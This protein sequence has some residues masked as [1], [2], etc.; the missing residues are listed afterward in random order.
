[1][2]GRH[3]SVSQKRLSRSRR[4]A[5]R[6]GT[7]EADRLEEL[8][9]RLFVIGKVRMHHR[10]Y[11]CARIGRMRARSALPI[12]TGIETCVKLKPEKERVRNASAPF[13]EKTRSVRL[14]HVLMSHAV[15]ARI[16]GCRYGTASLPTFSTNRVIS[17]NRANPPLA[18]SET[19]RTKQGAQDSP[20]YTVAR[21]T[22]LQLLR[23][24]LC[25]T[26]I[27][28]LKELRTSVDKSITASAW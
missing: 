2:I 27:G 28:R 4:K 13:S 20:V 16:P 22:N 23:L 6:S 21:V 1:M 12:K 26:L 24:E 25:S 9:R 19:R 5:N 10:G 11:R 17:T 3:E 18:H 8:F 15:K 14:L 7:P